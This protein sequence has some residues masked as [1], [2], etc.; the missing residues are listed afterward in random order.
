MSV[1]STTKSPDIQSRL[2]FLK[3]DPTQDSHF[4]GFTR[5]L[6]KTVPSILDKFYAH[7]LTVPS[8]QQ[9]IG[10]PQRIEQLKAA[11]LQHWTQMLTDQTSA[12]YG[13]SAAKIGQLHQKIGLEPR[14]YIAAYC[15]VL[16]EFAALAIQK[17]M[18]PPQKALGWIQALNKRVFL[19]MDLALTEYFDAV[20]YHANQ[21]LQEVSHQFE[22]QVNQLVQAQRET[23]SALEQSAEQMVNVARGNSE[24]SVMVG[25]AQE[26]THQNVQIVAS[27]AEELSASIADI[28]TQMATSAEIASHAVERA[29]RSNEIVEH[30]AESSQQISHVV[31]L[32]NEIA[33]QTHLLALNATIEAASAGD[34]GRGFAVVASEVK[35][36]ASQT[37]DATEEITTRIQSVQQE[38]SEA[39][40][41]IHQI[42]QV[43][44]EIN[45][46]AQNIASTIHQQTLAT[47]EISHNVQE[48]AMATSNVS[49]SLEQIAQS[50]SMTG[51]SASTVLEAARNLSEQSRQLSQQMDG[52]MASLARL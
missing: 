17:G 49:Q 16:N 9:K 47:N 26:Q 20:Q 10:N 51:N 43:I 7:I 2:D 24:Q 23:A 40:E 13:Q 18:F 14:W 33:G 36:L 21:K 34:A 22:Q 35:N 32:I 30:L 19:D 15:F 50:A 4:K 52:Y 46:I 28:S 1:T 11:Q 29:R 41:S 45:K 37:A 44:G 8:L 6:L 12:I 42:T 5:L 39:V 25:S 27:A 3:L 38:T 48:A 31:R